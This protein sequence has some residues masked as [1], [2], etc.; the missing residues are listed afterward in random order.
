VS[1]DGY[2]PRHVNGMPEGAKRVR[3]GGRVINFSTSIIGN[4]LSTYGV[5][6]A[7][8]AAVEAMTHVL[9]KELGTRSVTV[10]AVAPAPRRDRIVPN[11]QVR[12]THS[13]S[14][15]RHSTGTSGRTR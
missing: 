7:T 4:Y 14:D 6:A 5:Y 9:A 8:K 10:N 12:R 11:G 1:R 13:A 2:E 3:D 15:K